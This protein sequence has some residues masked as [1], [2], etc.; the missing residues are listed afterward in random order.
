MWQR[1][2]IGHTTARSGREGAIGKASKRNRTLNEL[3]VSEYE[4]QT[5]II[6][7]HDRNDAILTWCPKFYDEDPV[8]KV[9]PFPYQVYLTNNAME[10][11][12][13]I[14]KFKL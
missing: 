9:P 1:N 4:P 7:D 14:K 5:L 8:E 12:T 10:S 3:V 6:K 11:V 13:D 2:G